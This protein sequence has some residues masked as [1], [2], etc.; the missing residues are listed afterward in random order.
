MSLSVIHFHFF[1][2]FLIGFCDLTYEMLLVLVPNTL[3]T[4]ELLNSSLATQGLIEITKLEEKHS[5]SLISNNYHYM[6]QTYKV[7][8]LKNEKYIGRNIYTFLY[9]SSFTLTIQYVL[10]VF[11]LLQ[12]NM[13]CLFSFSY[14]T[15]CVVCFLSLIILHVLFIFSI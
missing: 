4:F 8:S 11:F 12:Y 15:I 13:C 10:S 2:L 1:S 7:H 5:P 9:S 6:Q 14:N 3:H